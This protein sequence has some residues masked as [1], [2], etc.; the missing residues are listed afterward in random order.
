MHA[1]LPTSAAEY[2]LGAHKLH[3]D[4]PAVLEY[5][6]RAHGVH[7]DDAPDAYSPMPHNLGVSDAPPVHA[8]PGGHGSATASADDEQTKPA[9]HKAGAVE[10]GAHT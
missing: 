1:E 8:F 9:G 2:V 6:P 7:E 10:P 3:A 4:A 5:K